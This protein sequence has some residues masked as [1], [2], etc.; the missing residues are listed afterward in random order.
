MWS[1]SAA[2][3]GRVADVNRN[4]RGEARQ[5]PTR[6]RTRASHVIN[7]IRGSELSLKASNWLPFAL[8]GKPVR[9]SNIPSDLQQETR[10]GRPNGRTPQHEVPARRA[11]RRGQDQDDPSGRRPARAGGARRPRTTSPPATAPSTTSSPTRAGSPRDHVQ[12]LPAAEGLRPAGGVRGAGQ[13]DLVRRAEMPH[14]ALRGGG[15]ARGAWLLS[16][17]QPAFREGTAVSA[18]DRRA[19]PQ[20]QGQELE[21]QAAHLRRSADDLCARSCADQAV[22][23]GKA[24]PGTG[25]VPGAVGVGGVRARRGMEAVPRDAAARAPCVPGAR[26][27]VAA[28]R[29]HAGRLQGRVRF[30]HQGPPAARGRDRQ[31]LLAGDRER[32]L[33]RQAGLPRRRRARRRDREIPAGRRHHR[34]LPAAAPADHP[35]ARIGEGQDRGVRGQRSAS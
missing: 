23:S 33:H 32:R 24:D 18:A 27:G 35:V 10:R 22:Q 8:G 28:R 7:R 29:R 30:R 21:G 20:D 14:A 17:A 19:L 16:Q 3:G 4:R 9:Q 2:F 11:G 13:R 25:A 12:C 31:R 15:A 26:E 5:V 6:R 1:L 34:P